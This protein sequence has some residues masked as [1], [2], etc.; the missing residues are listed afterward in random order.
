VYQRISETFV[1]DDAMRQRLTTLNPVASSRMANR[2][3][4]A[5]ERNY[6][7]PDAATLD[8]LRNAADE[9]EDRLEGVAAE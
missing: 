1:L 7:Q 9:M 5:H 8:A 2:L 3:L 4:E 6:W